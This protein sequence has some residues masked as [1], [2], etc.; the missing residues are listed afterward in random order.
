VPRSGVDDGELGTATGRTVGSVARP[1]PV[2]FVLGG[3]GLLGASEIGML[4]ALFETGRRPDLVVGTSVGALNGALVAADP[5]PAALDR[6]VALWQTMS[7]NE[8]FSVGL[9]RLR[10]VARHRTH[11]HPI[12]P[13]RD[14]I[15]RELGHADIEDLRVPFQCCAASIER[16]AETWFS[17]GPVSAAVTA[18]CAVPGLFPP[19]RIGD[20]HF[21]DGGIVNSIP[22]GRAIELG[23]TT[24]YVLHVGRITQP[25]TAPTRPWEVAMVAFEIA[26]RH[27]FARDM[28]EVPPGV[29]VHV[30]PAGDVVTPT[31]NLRYRDSRRVKVR[32]QQAYAAAR[33]YLATLDGDPAAPATQ[34]GTVG[35][36]GTGAGTRSAAPAPVR[37]ASDPATDPAEA[38]NLAT[39][40]A[41]TS[42]PGTDVAEADDLATDAAEAP[43][44]D[45]AD[46]GEPGTDA[47]GTDPAEADAAEADAAEADEADAA[48]ADAADAA[49]ADAADAAGADAADAAEADAGEAGGPGTDVPQAGGLATEAGSRNG[50]PAGAGRAGRRRSGAED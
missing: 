11:L 42:G 2:A 40:T 43:A 8:V 45:L 3:G 24:V 19:V 22:V 38:D 46:A 10:D 28:A 15:D 25:L 39:D 17:S 30:L 37:T 32:V 34:A 5:T 26:R 20:E 9:G 7:T 23:A 6:L 50:A 44:T 27:R 48:E 4:R 47:A 35:T 12:T 31:A 13:L 41:E 1:G 16:A 18:S 29:V 49:G 21:L 33:A 36:V 14:L